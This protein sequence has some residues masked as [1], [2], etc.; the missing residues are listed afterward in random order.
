MPGF[1]LIE[2]TIVVAILATLAAIAIP[3]YGIYVSRTQATVALGEIAAGKTAYELLL[4]Q[5]DA[6]A[7]HYT[8]D[9]LGLAAETD[10]CSV[11]TSPPDAGTGSI[12]CLLK[13]RSDLAGRTIT[14]TRDGQ[15][16]HC[17]STLDSPLLPGGCTP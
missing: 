13:G 12:A 16:W 1:T 4:S 5:G 8:P 11:S 10:Y 14:L 3:L 7:N 2:A 9:G 17:A 6:A 15:G